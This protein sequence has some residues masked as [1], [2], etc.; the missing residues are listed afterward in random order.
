MNTKKLLAL[1]LALGMVLSL[2][3][4]CG[5]SSSTTS[6]SVT[7]EDSQQDASAE[8][9]DDLFV[10][11]IATVDSTEENTNTEPTYTLPIVDEV[12]SYSFW[13]TYA[14]FAAELINVETLEGMLVLDTLQ[15]ITNIHFDFQTVNGAAEE[16]NFNLMIATGDYCDII[17]S[18]D[19]YSTGL[20]G[21]VEE[22][23]IMD[24]SD[25]LQESCPT[26]W[27]YLSSD[28][29]TLMRAYT[30]S[31]YM[32]AICVLY[33]ELGQESIGYVLR[34]DWL[35]EFGLEMPTTLAEMYEYLSAAY[36]QKGAIFEVVSTDGLLEAFGYGLNV[37]MGGFSVEDGEVIYGMTQD[38]FKVY[39]QFM[40]QLY[41]EGIISAD[42]FVD[43]NS[44]LS[45]QA[46]IDFGLGTNSL[47]STSAANTT[48]VVSNIT[49]DGFEM[50]VVPLLTV[51][52]TEEG[53][54]GP[55]TLT[56]IMKDTDPW[57][58]STTIGDIEPLLELVEYLY[59]DEG[60]LLTNYGVEG[61]TY[62]LDENGDP[63]WTDLIINNEDGLSFFFASY[64]YATNAASGFFPYLND[65]SRTYYDFNDNQWQVYED[66]KSLSACA[67]NYPAFATMT[68][69]E[70]A[71]YSS[72]ESD[73]STYSETKI[74]EFIV[75]SADIE[76]EFD[77]FVE[78]L[79]SMGLQDLIDIKQA[80]Y[81]RAMERVARIN[82]G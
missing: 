43:S 21:A 13:I 3:A 11:E 59:S 42:F 73:L 80:A 76:S 61:T 75:G 16:D 6:S 15:E 5:S 47:L 36:N 56:D 14:P 57:C 35:D 32:P 52:G 64:I 82:A 27:S 72:I 26:Y 38:N 22:E 53:H 68:T 2:F 49:E 50:A 66:L 51:D 29:N 62:T 17:A 69:D 74:L 48:D 55:D 9:D 81:D 79:Y 60:Y 41:T 77:S 34:Q 33:P 46:R 37:S 31:G 58:F 78:T 44:D 30:D 67:Y 8:D 10:P 40:N 65:M 23:I 24:L 20:E 54:L 39:L 70:S 12:V 25:V 45:S 19:F 18:M 1:L 7:S 4:G 28:V 63:Q 71:E